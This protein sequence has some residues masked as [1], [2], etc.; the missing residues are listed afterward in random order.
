M[1]GT[2]NKKYTHMITT[3]FNS[4]SLGK[5]LKFSRREY[6][7]GKRILGKLKKKR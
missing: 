6:Y 2:E 7:F 5:N 1:D 3:F 4:L